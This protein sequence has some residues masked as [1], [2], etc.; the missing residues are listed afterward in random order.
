MAVRN[1]AAQQAY[2]RTKHASLVRGWEGGLDAGLDLTRG[3]SDMRDFRFALR[4]ARK[5]GRDRLN[6][7]A[8]SF[9]ALDDVA[10]ARPHNTADQN[11]GGALFDRHLTARFFLF[12]NADF[13]ND[14]LQDLNLRSV[15]GGGLGHHLIQSDRA[16]LNLLGGA[17]F[18]R[19]NY[20]GIQRNLIAGQAGEEFKFKLEKNTSLIEGLAYFPDL[21]DPG[22]N[23][24]TNFGLSTVTRMA[25]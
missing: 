7:F 1:D 2:E 10:G 15:L 18:T 3:N 14:E 20:V 25:K 22:N 9:H 4:A 16:T 24:R 19:E 6:L 11:R 17:N 5:V 13:M 21:T 12:A 23:Y 8:E